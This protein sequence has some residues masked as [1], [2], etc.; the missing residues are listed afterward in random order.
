MK[1]KRLEY[2]RG[3]L[4]YISQI[5]ISTV[6]YFKDILSTRRSKIDEERCNVCPQESMTFL[7]GEFEV[8]QDTVLLDFSYLS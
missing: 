2:D 3:I 4:V 5:Y 7:K 1:F 6:S 8:A